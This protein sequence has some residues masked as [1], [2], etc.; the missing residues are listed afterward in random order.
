MENTL[1]RIAKCRWKTKM[2]RRSGFW[3]VDLTAAAQELLVGWLAARVA[4]YVCNLEYLFS[5]MNMGSDGDSE[6]HLWLMSKIPTRTWDDCRGT[7]ERKSRI[8]SY[9]DLLAC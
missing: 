7:S 3:Q 2:D 8:H 4:E 5:R 1:E 9:E 6:P